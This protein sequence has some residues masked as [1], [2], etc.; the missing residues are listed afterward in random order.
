[1]TTATLETQKNKALSFELH[2]ILVKAY[3][4][5]EITSPMIDVFYD[6]LSCKYKEDLKSFSFIDKDF[7]FIF[8]LSHYADD[9]EQYIRFIFWGFIKQLLFDPNYLSFLQRYDYNNILQ[10]IIS[11]SNIDC[12]INNCITVL[13]LSVD[14]EH[15]IIR[16]NLH[17]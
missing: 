11:S 4:N 1:M 10:E 12:I 5:T 13:N 9:I 6:N 14:H 7:S 3:E 16:V 17:N 15:M 2:R 8:E